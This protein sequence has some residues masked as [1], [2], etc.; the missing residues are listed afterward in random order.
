MEIAIIILL[1][2]VLL[3]QAL[4]LY[5]QNTAR[6]K[7][8]DAVP[9]DKSFQQSEERQQK[10]LAALKEDLHL[11][12]QT[13]SATGQNSTAQQLSLMERRLHSLESSNEDKLDKIR[14]TVAQSLN[15]QRVENNQRLEDIRGTVDERLQSTLETRISESFQSVSKQ[16]EEVY[17]GLGEMKNLAND[18]GGLKQ[19]LSGV[20][21]RGILGEVQLEAILQEILAPEQYE[22]NVATVPGSGNRVEFA[23]RLPGQSEGQPVYLPIDSKFPGDRY[24][25]LQEAQA[26]GDRELVAKAEKELE[27]VLRSE[28]KDIRDKYLKE[29]YTTN[30]GIMFLPFEGLYA[31]AVNMGMVE[32]LQTEYHVNIAGPSTMA[33]LLNALQMGFQTLAIQKR[34]SEVWQVLSEVKTE[35]AKFE[36]ILTKMQGHLNQTSKDLDALLTTRTRAINR[37][38]KDV[39]TALPTGEDSDQA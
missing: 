39:Q 7:S 3:V 8:S 24:A 21:T 23:I 31:E 38:L 6:K 13:L 29:P 1:I 12:L 25:Q 37:K 18:V 10:Q 36:E 15:Q 5:Q 35:F 4:V 33:A 28:A 20:K 9:W 2:L 30:F 11:T 14:Q 26:Q 34:S 19:V 17:K 16:L 27:K 22:T 32:R